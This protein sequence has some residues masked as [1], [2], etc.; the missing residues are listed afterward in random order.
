[1][2]RRIRFAPV[3]TLLLLT[4]S[5]LFAQTAPFATGFRSPM[6]LALTRNG[7][8]V[9]IEA[10]SG[11]NTGRI[12]LVDRVT[13]QRRTLID[14][15]PSG[16]HKV[17]PPAPSGPTSVAI[18]GGTMYVLIGNGDSV[19]PGP[20]PATEV[21][22]PTPSSPILSSLLALRPSEPLELMTGG[23]VLDPSHHARLKSG[24]TLTLTNGAGEELEIRLVVDFPNYTEEPRPDFPQNVRL[25]NPFG[26]AAL[27]QTLFVVDA[28][29][30]LIRRVDAN[31][32]A[33]TT[34]TTFAK[35][36]NPTP[37]GPPM[38]DAV[39][40]SIRVR[41]DKLLVT[42]LT[43]F[44]FPAGLAEVR[45]VDIATGTNETLIGGLTSAIDVIPLG[46]SPTSA[47][48]VAE[49]STAQT[50]GQ[51]GR[52]RLVAPGASPVTLA[53]GLITPTGLA[54]D[55][56]SGEIFVSNLGPSI[57]TRIDAATRI[58][59]SL[60]DA[61]IP[62]VASTAGAFGSQFRT[63]LQISNPYSFSIHG[64]IVF[65]PAGTQ[66]SAADPSLSYSLLPHETK[67]WDDV[68]TSAGGTGLGSADVITTAGDAP[69]MVVQVFDD[70]SASSAS[71]LMPTVSPSAALVA[72]SRGSLITP[73]DPHQ[74]RF[75]VGIRA[76]ESGVTL[77]ITVYDPAGTALRSVSRSYPPNYFV[78]VPLA[79]L[80]EGPLAANQSIVFEVESGSAIVYGSAADNSG[81]G[82]TVQVA[83]PASDE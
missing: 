24:E 15:L 52:V 38:I 13:A 67:S 53:E 16:I 41:G 33:Y 66:G 27:G 69:S 71:V 70:A 54:V 39:P 21:P 76:L 74:S 49:F 43:G 50:Q 35:L 62:A 5:A 72:G 18:Q 34:L 19:N 20:L 32:G 2:N 7:Q 56:Q 58:P 75:N 79:I 65:H 17:T 59:L 46:S 26:I 12:S 68:V 4:A 80:T 37:V 14:A 60:P 57:I 48:V 77:T 63:S 47:M 83:T 51:P 40:D 81:R 25:L 82:M 73:S 22:N 44:P 30:N 8:L 6:E 64:R 23:F 45:I 31:T 1:M 61:I 29:Q 55:T 36:Q 78:Q 10:G 11:P 42:L 9:V 28:G 3:F